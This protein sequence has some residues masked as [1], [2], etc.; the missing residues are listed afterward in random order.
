MAS[1]NPA[2]ASTA[3]N[4]TTNSIFIITGFEITNIKIHATKSNS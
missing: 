3:K 1:S 4:K 2:N